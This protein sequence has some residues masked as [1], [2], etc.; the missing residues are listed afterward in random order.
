MPQMI[1]VNLPVADL[2]RAKTF[3][4]ALGF[5]IDPQFSDESGACVVVSDA[6]YLMILTHA[7]FEEFAALPRADTSKVTAAL[8]ALSRD[9]RQGVDGMA[10]AALRAGGT[11]PRSAQDHG[12]MYGRS[13]H[14]PDGNVLE[15]F[16]M[17]P[18][19][20]GVS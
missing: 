5:T 6:I 10:D 3:Y 1:F 20:V 7:R 9:N 14:D 15:A 8:I 2:D 18:A 11:E 19:A 12:F 17:D 16:W 13:L 4:E